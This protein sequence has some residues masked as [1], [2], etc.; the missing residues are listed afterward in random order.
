M[1]EGDFSLARIVLEGFQLGRPLKSG[2]SALNGETSFMLDCWE[3]PRRSIV[4]S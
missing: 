1:V 3:G 2:V 4:G